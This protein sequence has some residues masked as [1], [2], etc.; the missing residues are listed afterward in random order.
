V[1]YNHY[2]WL[3]T[4]EDLPN[5][6]VNQLLSASARRPA[7]AVQG[8]SVSVGLP[9][10]QVLATAVGPETPEQGRFPVPATSPCTFILT[11]AAASSVLPISPS[12][13]FTL[14]DEFGHVRHP[15]VTALDGG[16]RPGSSSRGTPC[17]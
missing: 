9:D 15:R 12:S 3:R 14:V 7:L 1:H 17:H 16:P 8:E 2:S 11:F 13:S 6:S 10:G 4:M 5:R